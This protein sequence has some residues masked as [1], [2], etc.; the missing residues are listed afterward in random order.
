MRRRGKPHPTAHGD[1]QPAVLS[2]SLVAASLTAVSLLVPLAAGSALGLEAAPPRAGSASPVR[3]GPASERAALGVALRPRAPRPIAGRGY[4]VVFEDRFNRLR[5]RVWDNREW[6]N[7]GPP[8]RS[9]YVRQGKLHL[10][11]RRSQGYENITVTTFSSRK[12][13]KFGYFEARIKWTKGI[14]SWPAFWLMSN[15]WARRGADDCSLGI[16]AAEIDIFEGYGQYPRVLNGAIHRNSG[17]HVCPDPPDEFNP[18]SFQPQGFDL[19]R[20]FHTYAARW[21]P[22]RVTWFLDQR[23]TM[24]WPT[25]ET[26]DTRMFILLSTQVTDDPPTDSSTPNQLRTKIDWVRVWQKR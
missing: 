11:S 7:T 9:Q 14:G 16:R 10:V 15:A 1:S 8:R 23:R 17:G 25:Y 19:T 21:T 18:N 3:V 12:A 26:T 24:S 4:R 6:W 22:T 5:R 13:F 2:R 20:R